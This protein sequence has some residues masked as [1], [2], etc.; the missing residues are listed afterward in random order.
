MLS[1][2]SSIQNV[3]AFG[4][5]V[6]P[7]FKAFPFRKHTNCALRQIQ[8]SQSGLI[9]PGVVGASTGMVLF[10]RAANWQRSLFYSMKP[11]GAG[12]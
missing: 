8:T 12:A 11:G 9:E 4:L 7:G 6:V 5:N 10:G 3:P 1:V 2:R